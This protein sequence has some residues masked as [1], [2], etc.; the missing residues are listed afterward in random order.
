M[1]KINARNP[2][3]VCSKRVYAASM[4]L[5][6]PYASYEEYRKLLDACKTEYLDLVHGDVTACILQDVEFDGQ[7][8]GH[9]IAESP[10]IHGYAVLGKLT[11]GCLREWCAQTNG[12]MADRVKCAYRA[13]YRALTTPAR[14]RQYPQLFTVSCVTDVLR[15][16]VETM[17]DDQM[18][19]ELFDDSFT[20]NSRDELIPVYPNDHAL[21]PENKRA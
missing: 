9:G 13:C 18:F 17:F 8:T 3:V 5:I 1:A 4:R 14:S 7:D 2:C 16:E 12:I 21:E 11:K 6:V 19:T 15:D 10:L 20:L